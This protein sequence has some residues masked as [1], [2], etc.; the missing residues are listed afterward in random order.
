M[1]TL[2]SPIMSRRMTGRGFS[3][4]FDGGAILFTEHCE[5]IFGSLGGL[6][7]ALRFVLARAAAQRVL[8]HSDAIRGAVIDGTL[9]PRRPFCSQLA[10]F[11]L[12]LS[13]IFGF[14]RIRVRRLGPVGA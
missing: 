5:L 12:F 8:T 4:F 13:Q 6:I 14:H 7:D 9:W 2:L 11:G 1:P 3:G 10:I